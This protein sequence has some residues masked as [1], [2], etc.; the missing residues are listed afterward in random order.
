M[1]D[2]RQTRLAL[3][4]PSGRGAVATIGVRG[5]Q[6]FEIVGRRFA[7]ASGQPLT[8]YSPGRVLFGRFSLGDRG[9]EELVVG[10]VG[11]G[12]VEVHCH[13]G[14]AVV[15]AVAAALV[16]E[17]ARRIDAHAW[18]ALCESDE[19]AAEAAIALAAATTE[20]IALIL[21]DQYRGALSA[22]I[23]R[24][25]GALRQSNAQAARD[26]L[27]AVL[28]RSDLGRHLTTPWR[29]V[30]A[31]RPNVGKSSLINA[32]LG[33]Q[34]AIVFDQPGTTRDVLAASAAFDGWPV[35][36]IDMAGLRAGGDAIEAAGVERAQG[37]IAAAD[38]VLFV[39]D[40]SIAW[41]AADEQ[42]WQ[43]VQSLTPALGQPLVIHNKYDLSPPP[44]DGRPA[45]LAVSALAGSGLDDLQRQIAARLVP[46]PPPAGAA[47]PFTQRQERLLR[48]ALAAV[49]RGET[50]AAQD[51]LHSI[52]R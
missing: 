42:L 29:I 22:A 34:R 46:Y 24:A 14:L 32:L 45:G 41:T 39:C 35:M 8:A 4:T 18:A 38:L 36:L 40:A 17:G 10:L 15:E 27:A 13:G 21:L 33:Y 9:T 19:I 47:V 25:K 11:A 52:V 37:E 28:A 26:E 30:L 5:P 48:A 44:S 6:A 2:E 23:G 7:A 31:G 3:L 43:N 49:E 12:E 16:A 1:A 50:T 20:R 51:W